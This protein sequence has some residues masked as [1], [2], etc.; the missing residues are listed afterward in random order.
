M[1]SLN[2]SMPSIMTL[3]IGGFVT[4]V[5]GYWL[6]RVLLPKPIPGIPHSK[7]SANRI[8]GDVPDLLAW[9]AKHGDSFGYLP[10][11]AYDHNSPI[12]QVFMRPFGRPWVFV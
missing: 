10:Q 8:L 3:G 9:K 4:T 5:I 1:A 2:V 7:A 12:F 6:R 11:L